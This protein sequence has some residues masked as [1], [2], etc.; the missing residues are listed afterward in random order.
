MIGS[1][2]RSKRGTRMKKIKARMKRIR[3]NKI[4]D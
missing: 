1:G 2:D 4:L 3:K